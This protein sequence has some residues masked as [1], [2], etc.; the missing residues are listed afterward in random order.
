MTSAATVALYLLILLAAVEGFASLAFPPRS[1]T[2]SSGR[3]L[4][5]IPTSNI[6]NSKQNGETNSSPSRRPT[7]EASEPICRIVS[8]ADSKLPTSSS[9]LPESMFKEPYFFEKLDAHYNAQAYKRAKRLPYL[10][11]TRLPSDKLEL[12]NNNDEGQN[13]EEEDEELIQFVRNS[14]T[15]AG[16]QL[17]TRR[18]LDLCDSLNVGYLLRLSLSPDISDLDPGIAQQFY[19]EKLHGGMLDE[20]EDDDILFGGRC[21]VFWRGYSEEVTTGR[22]IIP[23]IDYLQTSLVRRSATWVNKGLDEV[24]KKLTSKADRQSQ[25]FQSKLQDFKTSVVPS[26]LSSFKKQKEDDDNQ[27]AN[28]NLTSAA[29]SKS[30]G[31]VNLGRYGGSNLRFIGSADPD[32]ALDPFMVCEVEVEND[33]DI[34]DL[35]GVEYKMNA[36]SNHRDYSCEYDD[37]MTNNLGQLAIPRIH[38]LERVSINNLVN[39]FTN[40]GR[41]TLV[42]ALSEESK[43]VEPTYEEVSN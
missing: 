42:R 26:S 28:D 18:D 10:K 41:R 2:A 33:D 9:Q 30:K 29:S 22:L 15:D 11:T 13:E 34:D 7:E 39:V 35:M 16:F 37:S 40:Y 36:K 1:S 14:L 31:G 38:L 25:K 43:L 23:K 17:L 12:E 6:F 4:Q 19:P 24:E 8:R 32:D 20:Q 21:L 3:S 27:E 5:N